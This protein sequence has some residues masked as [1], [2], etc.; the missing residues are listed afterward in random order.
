M[1]SASTLNTWRPDSS[2]LRRSNQCSRMA[3]CK[4]TFALRDV[5][6]GY[7]LKVRGYS[8]HGVR[9]AAINKNPAKQKQKSAHLWPSAFRSLRRLTSYYDDGLAGAANTVCEPSITGHLRPRQ[10]YCVHPT[11]RSAHTL[12]AGC[13]SLHGKACLD[14]TDMA[15]FMMDKTR[16]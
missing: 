16:T 11:C 9:V 10:T 3:G 7:H 13:M 2:R 12:Y 14:M 5:L 15:K 6:D 8:A 1:L 4:L